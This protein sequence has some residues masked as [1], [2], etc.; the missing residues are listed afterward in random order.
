[1]VHELVE[2]S[3]SMGAHVVHIRDGDDVLRRH[4]GSSVSSVPSSTDNSLG[5]EVHRGSDTRHGRC[6]QWR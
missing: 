6:H 4:G 2:T 3:F 1:V 5:Q